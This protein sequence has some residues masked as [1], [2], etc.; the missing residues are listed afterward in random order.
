VFGIALLF[1][2]IAVLDL[3]LLGAWR[4]IPIASLATPAV[5]IAGTGLVLA[6]T[7]GVLLL[8]AQATEYVTNPFLYIKFGAIALGVVNVAALH[9]SGVW[10]AI[11]SASATPRGRAR[12][13]IAG[14]ASL[15]CWI[16]TIS[17]GRMIAYW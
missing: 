17:A 10:R 15:A 4:R 2:G 3:R 12:M 6:L 11:E 1:G 8:S 7:S 9:V 5:P 16:T 13:A 14:A